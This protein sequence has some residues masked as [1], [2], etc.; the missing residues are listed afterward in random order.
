MSETRHGPTPLLS[1]ASLLEALSNLL[2]GTCFR[3]DLL[4]ERQCRDSRGKEYVRSWCKNPAKRL[5]SDMQLVRECS[6]F[7]RRKSCLIPQ[8][9]P[10]RQSSLYQGIRPL[11]SFLMPSKGVSW[12]FNRLTHSG[13]ASFDPILTS[14]LLNLA[15]NCHSSIAR[16][17]VSAQKSS[18]G[19]CLGA[20]VCLLSWHAKLYGLP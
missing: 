2:K 9:R 15:Y 20:V 11:T 10:C 6:A 3:R 19:L 14:S 16:P 5:F 4:T 18:R 17:L 1:Y 7:Q 8:L 12:C 13:N